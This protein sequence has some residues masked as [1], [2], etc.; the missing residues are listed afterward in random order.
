MLGTLFAHRGPRSAATGMP[1]TFAFRRHDREATM[2]TLLARNWGW[3][4]LRG[5]A[6]VIFGLLTVMNPGITLAVLILFFGAFS[7]IDGILAVIAAIRN[8][9]AESHWVTLLI[10]GIA[11]I[12]IGVCTFLAPG[13]SAIVLLYFIAV[14][15]LIIGF[16]EIMAAIRLR[17]IITGE[18]MLVL[19]GVASVAL[20]LF[21]LSRP[22]VGAIALVIWI[23]VYAFVSGIL[24]IA[25]AFELRRWLRN[26]PASMPHPA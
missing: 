16:S 11:G 26:R 22:A 3:I 19:A 21:L 6:A 9:K 2:D 23:G 14:W 20:G 15:A 18:W 4:A 24:L 12:I 25:L 17:K 10:G 8:R 13:I 5:V 7:L 1:S